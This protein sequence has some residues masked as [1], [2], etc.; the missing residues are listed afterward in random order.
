MVPTEAVADYVRRARG[1]LA[2]EEI[3]DDEAA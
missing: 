2:F 3:P 1:A